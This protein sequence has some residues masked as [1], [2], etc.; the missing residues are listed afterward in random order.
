VS[1]LQ[2]KSGLHIKREPFHTQAAL[3]DLRSLT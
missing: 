2:K 3:A 1:R